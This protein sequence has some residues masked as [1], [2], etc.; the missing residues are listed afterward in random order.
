MSRISTFLA[1]LALANASFAT[2]PAPRRTPPSSATTSSSTPPGSSPC[3]FTDADPG[4]AL[5][6]ARPDAYFR[7][8]GPRSFVVDRGR[9]LPYAADRAFSGVAPDLGA[10]ELETTSAAGRPK[11]GGV[12]DLRIYP[13]PAPGSVLRVATPAAG[14][15]ELV[16]LRGRRARTGTLPA[17]GG[18][19]DVGGLPA[20]S[21]WL[22]VV[23]DGGEVAVRAVT[24]L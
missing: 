15:Y 23:G 6:G 20:G 5:V 13:N 24:L 4:F 11:L 17:G 21:Y 12:G 7:P 8:A 22:R 3:N 2:T 14:A 1:A 16:D 10:M 19:L 9:V 18:A